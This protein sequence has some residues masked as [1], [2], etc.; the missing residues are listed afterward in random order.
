MTPNSSFPP[1]T[2]KLFDAVN[3]SADTDSDAFDIG[4]CSLYSIQYSWVGSSGTRSVSA[5]CSNDGVIWTNFD[6]FSITNSDDSRMLNVERAA[7][8]FI[9]ISYTQTTGVGDLTIVVHGKG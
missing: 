2:V 9:R 3:M 7:Y 4:A 1:F 5:Q 6:T 8:P